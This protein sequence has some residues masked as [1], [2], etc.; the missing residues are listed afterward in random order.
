MAALTAQFAGVAV[1][2][3]VTKSHAKR[4]LAVRAGKYDDELLETATKMTMPGKGILAMDESNATCGGRLEGVGVENIEENRRR[5]REL[6]IT[7]PNLGEHIGGAILFEETLY[8]SC[9]DG[10][11]FVDALK[12]QG[13]YPGIKVD[14]GLRPLANSNGESWC[15][16]MDD[17]A[18][19][20]AA[21]YEQG[22]RFCKWRS[23]VSI[24]QG[25]SKIA[26]RDCAYGLARY[27]AVCQNAGLVPIVEPEILLDGDHDIERNFEVASMVWAETFKYLADNNVAFDRMLLKPSM[28]GPGADCPKRNTPEEVAEATLRMLNSRVPPQTAGIMFLS[29]GLSELDSTLYLNAMNQAPNPWHVSFSYARA[30]Q[31]TVIKTWAGNDEKVGEAQAILV[32]RA[33]ENGMAQLGKF[34]AGEV[35]D[36]ESE[37]T[38]QKNYVY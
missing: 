5:Y 14:K 38:Y 6:L 18:D 20:A 16:G 28:V 10:T 26:V 13:I 11:S 30:L 19:R 17:L 31:N 15:Q 27:A 4:N 33:K 3:R 34:V 23:V 37:S 24:P 2:A 22:A 21:Y 35:S 1:T 25:P 8:Q 36:S 29:G 7:A 9:S 32:R 12:A